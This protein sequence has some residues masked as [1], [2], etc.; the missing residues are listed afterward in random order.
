MKQKKVIALLATLLTFQ[1][2]QSYCNTDKQEIKFTTLFKQARQLAKKGQTKKAIA[3]YKQLLKTR[4]ENKFLRFALL[5]TQLDNKQY[6]EEDMC[7]DIIDNCKKILEMDPNEY[8]GHFFWAVALTHLGEKEKAIQ[9]YIKALKLNKK[10]SPVWHNTALLLRQKELV[11]SSLFFYK[12]AID[13]APHIESYHFGIAQAYLA[14]GDFKNGWHHMEQGRRSF[15]KQLKKRITTP[16]QITGKTVLVPKSWGYGDEIQFVR[17]AQKI[18]EHGGIVLMHVHKPVAKIIATCKYVDKVTTEP[19]RPHQYDAQIALWSLPHLFDSTEK[20][21]PKEI[22]YLYANPEL[23]SYWNKK[24]AHDKN[25]KIG[26]CWSGSGAFKKIKDIPLQAFAPLAQIPGITLYSLQKGRGS[27]QTKE[28]DFDIV[29]F[30]DEMDK[31]HGA[32][33]DTAA[34]MKNIDLVITVDT[35]TAHLAGA[36]GVPVWTYIIF[37]PDWRWMLKRTDTP[38]YPT[39]KLFRGRKPYDGQYAIQQM[40]TEIEQMLNQ[41]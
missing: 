16:D 6:V 14:L 34:I 1:I 33:M 20:T 22:P 17:Y 5:A 37:A 15:L 31:E 2:Y 27:E 9:Q 10:A 32:F 28:I 24:L 7:R 12:K 25:F 40:K 18:K 21:I 23:C 41:S 4:P 26:I 29:D 30:S 38:W 39:M 11:N 13:L 8:R 35:S 19:A 36:L 3:L